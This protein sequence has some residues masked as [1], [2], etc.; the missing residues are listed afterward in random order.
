MLRRIATYL[1]P[2]SI[3][4]VAIAGVA[5]LARA[6]FGEI[7]GTLLSSGENEDA[8][9]ITL[10][11]M[12]KPIVEMSVAAKESAQYIILSIEDAGASQ[13]T[14][15]V[16]GDWRLQESRGVHAS[17]IAT[18]QGTGRVTHIIP[19]TE[20]SGGK[21]EL[22]FLATAPFAGIAFSHD[23]HSPALFTLIHLTLTDG[24]SERKSKI[25]E[26]SATVEL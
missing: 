19:F 10:Y 5:L 12:T 18:Y 8:A 3:F 9:A 25:V 22:R 14:L 11:G 24:A 1:L 15:T 4:L 16:P 6:P 20:N 23:A 26:E 13:A 21:I 17:S 7:Y 2:A